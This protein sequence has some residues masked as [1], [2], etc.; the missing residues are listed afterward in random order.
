MCTCDVCA[1][2][3]GL[4]LLVG[5]WDCECRHTRASQCMPLC[6]CTHVNTRLVMYACRRVYTCHCLSYPSVGARMSM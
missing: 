1:P 4:M 5:M 2:V 3:S 6:L